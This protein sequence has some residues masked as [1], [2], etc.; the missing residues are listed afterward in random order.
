MPPGRLKITIRVIPSMVKLDTTHFEV[1]SGSAVDL[2]FENGSTMPH[3]LVLIRPSA[4]DALIAG[5]N[6][7]GAAGMQKHFVPAV[8]G[9]L[10]ASRLLQ[11]QGSAVLAFTA[12]EEPGKHPFLCTFPGH[13]FTMRGVMQV[14]PRGDRLQAAQRD[15]EKTATVPDSLQTA[16]ISHRPRG[17][18]NKPLLMCTF[19]PDPAPAVFA[20]HGVGL[21]AFKYDPATR[22]DLLRKK[23]DPS[24][25][26]TE[27]IPQQVP[28]Q[29]GVQG[30]IAVNH[31]ETLS[32]AWDT[33]GRG[34]TAGHPA[35]GITAPGSCLR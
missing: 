28:T 31:G 22:N 9:I 32:S 5:V 34:R 15:T 6:A 35:G 10:A 29:P 1:N 26:K 33:T 3:N 18:L 16:R 8:P 11:P 20:H 24:T 14:R 17:T 2:R 13:W 4:E 23:Q 25:G 7:L 30:A 19:L 21:P 12:P 27:E